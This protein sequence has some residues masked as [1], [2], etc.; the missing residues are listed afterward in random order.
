MTLSGKNQA[1]LRAFFLLAIFLGV[2]GAAWSTLKK[3]GCDS[4]NSASL[5]VGDLNLGLIG[6]IFYGALL[7]LT[8][9]LMRP[10]RSL[11]GQGIPPTLA[12][13]V[14]LAGGV[15][16]TLVALL[17]KN[18]LVCASCFTT[19]AGGFAATALVLASRTLQF[20]WSVLIV[21]L[22]AAA[23]L[24]GLKL[25]KRNASQVAV[26]QAYLA[27]QELLRESPP[28]DGVARLVVFVRP[29]CHVCKRF[30]VQV[31]TPLRQEFAATQLHIEERPAW[32]GMAT[33]TSIVLGRRSVLMVGF[34]DLAAVRMAV[35]EARGRAEDKRT[36]LTLDSSDG[37]SR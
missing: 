27:R 26:R 36:A 11:P 30:K 20:R 17:F 21:A 5:L 2:V 23:T 12:L 33:P 10:H 18:H 3:D 35:Q 7:W 19:A 25:T 16:L 14:L 31:L 15:H 37:V 24:G 34:K 22:M 4:C 29:T 32:K 9:W 1:A 13:P 6:L 28:V 8:L